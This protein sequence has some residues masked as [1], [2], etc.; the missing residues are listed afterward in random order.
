MRTPECDATQML[1]VSNANGGFQPA[2][3]GF[4]AAMNVV[5]SETLRSIWNQ[6][7]KVE[8]S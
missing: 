7:R 2:P 4:G 8:V 6:H 3:I 5:F 1:G